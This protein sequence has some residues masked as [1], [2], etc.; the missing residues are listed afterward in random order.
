MDS[1]V[2]FSQLLWFPYVQP[3]KYLQGHGPKPRRTRRGP[4]H[5]GLFLRDGLQLLVAAVLD[6]L[7][8][9]DGQDGWPAALQLWPG[10][11]VFHTWGNTGRM[12]GSGALVFG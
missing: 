2:V 8:T 11:V 1:G 4:G 5:G 9:G 7:R 3:P 12:G 10:A 6:H